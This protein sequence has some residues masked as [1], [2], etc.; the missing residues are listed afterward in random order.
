MINKDAEKVA[1][2]YCHKQLH[3]K[4]NHV[5]HVPEG[6]RQW[7]LGFYDGH[8]FKDEFVTIQPWGLPDGRLLWMGIS[9]TMNTIVIA[10]F[11]EAAE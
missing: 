7:R 8:I 4:P 1:V 3:I 5:I 11:T 2:E 9:N 10:G 6:I